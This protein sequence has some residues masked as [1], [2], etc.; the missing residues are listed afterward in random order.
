LSDEPE[1]MVCGCREFK[2]PSDMYF[3]L[4]YGDT[5]PA[6]RNVARPV[7][8]IGCDETGNDEMACSHTDSSSKQN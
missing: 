1:F 8:L 5:D 2:G 3:W 4:T 7:V 6:G